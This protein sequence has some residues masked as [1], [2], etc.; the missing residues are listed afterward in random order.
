MSWLSEAWD[1]VSSIF[2][3]TP[4]D[5]S[6]MGPLADADQYGAMLD[7]VKKGKDALSGGGSVWGDIATAAVPTIISTYGA[8][9]LQS[10][11]QEQA[12]KNSN[13]I[14]AY[15]QAQIDLDKQK[16]ALQEK[17]LAQSGGS[18]GA[19]AAIA[20][21]KLLLDQY[22]QQMAARQAAASGVSSSLDKLGDNLQRPF[23]MLGK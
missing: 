17:A 13:T 18:A 19:M 1:T 12:D 22:N 4:V 15:Q 6:N 8:S 7:A 23:A 9:Q 5:T 16:L 11:Q 21:K 14:S 10:A 3:S 2:D 20:R